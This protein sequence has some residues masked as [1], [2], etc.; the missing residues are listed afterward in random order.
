[1]MRMAN[2]SA[3]W[4]LSNKGFTSKA[5]AQLLL[6]SHDVYRYIPC[7]ELVTFLSLFICVQDISQFI[8]F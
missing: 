7:Y 3:K 8:L 5:N 4:L 1:M 2:F 6:L